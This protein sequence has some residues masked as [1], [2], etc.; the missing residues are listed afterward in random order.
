MSYRYTGA[1]HNRPTIVYDD[2]LF[3]NCDSNE[4]PMEIIQSK[5]IQIEQKNSIIQNNRR[6]LVSPTIQSVS[7]RIRVSITNTLFE[8][9]TKSQTSK[10]RYCK[11]N[12]IGEGTYGKVFKAVNRETNQTVAIKSITFSSEST[13]S[14]VSLIIIGIMLNYF[15][16]LRNEVLMFLM[17]SKFFFCFF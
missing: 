2:D 17:K 10:S 7:K 16:Y 13:D 1:L 12:K 11:Y 5:P 8:S 14:R 6:K 3:L 15:T 4:S 9:N